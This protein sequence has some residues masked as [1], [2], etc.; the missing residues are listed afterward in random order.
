MAINHVR[1]KSCSTVVAMTPRATAKTRELESAVD[2]AF[3]RCSMVS[4]DKFSTVREFVAMKLAVAMPRKEKIWK[5][6]LN[7][8]VLGPKAASWIVD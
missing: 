1:P 3:L 7:R 5:T 4:G 6:A 2:A 8:A